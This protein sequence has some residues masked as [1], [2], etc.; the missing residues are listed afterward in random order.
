MPL[1]WSFCDRI[2]VRTCVFLATSWEASTC[3]ASRVLATLNEWLLLRRVRLLL[4]SGVTNIDN[5]VPFGVLILTSLA[6]HALTLV[7]RDCNFGSRWQF[8]WSACAAHKC[9]AAVSRRR[10]LLTLTLHMGFHAGCLRCA[11]LVNNSFGASQNYLTVAN[12]VE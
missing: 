4:S 6:G 12:I 5:I 2:L 8:V 3:R 7:P 10:S 1:A 9:S 11:V